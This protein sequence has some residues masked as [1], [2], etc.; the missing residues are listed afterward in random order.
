MAAWVEKVKVET[1][2]VRVKVVK[3]VKVPIH[4]TNF[5]HN[6]QCKCWQT[7]SN[8]RPAGYTRCIH[9]HSSTA[10]RTRCCFACAHGSEILLR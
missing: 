8:N 3:V 6:L 9:P 7:A 10:Q 2:E 1:A 4:H 5:R